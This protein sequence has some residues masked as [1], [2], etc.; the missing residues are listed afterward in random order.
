MQ[1]VLVAVL[2]PAIESAPERSASAWRSIFVGAG[3]GTFDDWN[4]VRVSASQRQV[5]IIAGSQAANTFIEAHFDAIAGALAQ[6]C[7]GPVPLEVSQRAV[8]VRSGTDKLWAYRFPKL[9]VEKNPG[10]WSA[11]FAADLDPALKAS[12]ERKVERSIRRELA[13][14]GRLP[15]ALDNEVPFLVL[16]QPGRAMPIQAVTAQRSGHGKAVT[17]LT[18][19]HPVFL[20]YWR[21]EGH[22][23]A[24][25]LASLGFGRIAR[26]EAPEL[27]DRGVQKALLDII[28]TDYPCEAV[29]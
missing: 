16:A 28:P 17:V 4:T 2:P 9:V 15:S 26:T 12:I 5:W 11:H 27:I 29:L 3:I 14:W 1:T 23:F 22:L 7:N 10:D 8:G 18:R 19:L 21:L 6:A 24:G 25:P 20:S 13:E